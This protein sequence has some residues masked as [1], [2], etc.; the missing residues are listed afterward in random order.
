M[1]MIFMLIF[2][3]VFVPLNITALKISGKPVDLVL[4]DVSSI[5]GFFLMLFVIRK[6]Y[7]PIVI[8]LF[9]MLIYSIF[10]VGFLSGS[11]PINSLLS[12]IKNYKTFF[13]IFFG[14][15]LAKK[16]PEESIVILR[17]MIYLVPLMVMVSDVLYNPRWPAPRWG[18]FI[19]ELEVYGFPNSAVF[20]YVFLSGLIYWEMLSFNKLRS[21]K[22]IILLPWILFILMSAS[23]NAFLGLIIM[24]SMIFWAYKVER[25]KLI[26]F[27]MLIIL[28]ILMGWVDLGWVLGKFERGSEA[29]N[30]FY[31][32]SLV[33]ADF[34][35]LLNTK[36]N[37]LTGSSYTF[38]LHTPH[39]QYLEVIY[40]SGVIG[41][42]FY[43]SL[44]FFLFLI[45]KRS[46]NKS[47][48]PKRA[49]DFSKIIIIIFL[50]SAISNF[51]QPNWS[52]T[53]FNILLMTLFGFVM[54]YPYKF[55]K[56]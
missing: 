41:L 8:Y 33:W 35:D 56:N 27:C 28:V 31:G 53:V 10:L 23:R 2:I 17:L 45:I 43:L 24:Y 18:G 46:L 54:E 44:Y 16:Y 37:W 29:G 49:H 20:F 50:T 48:L 5:I 26:L 52:Y 47:D 51:A 11:N 9:L 15:F 7:I 6:K 13:S 42:F 4:G 25:Y 38:S 1:K 14:I 21:I 34:I 55:R 40:K 19:G 12:F 22:L 36:Y 30:M 32:R 3:G 39:Q